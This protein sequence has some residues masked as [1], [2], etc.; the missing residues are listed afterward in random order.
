MLKVYLNNGWDCELVEE[1][2]SYE[3]LENFLSKNDDLSDEE[4]YE[5]WN[6]EENRWMKSYEL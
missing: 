4:Y 3:E 5:V 1:L 6:E 2:D